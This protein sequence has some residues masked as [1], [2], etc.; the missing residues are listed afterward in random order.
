M[1]ELATD[2][3]AGASRAGCQAS[4]GGHVS[5]GGEDVGV[6]DVEEDPG[7]CPNSDTGHRGQDGG[8]RVDIKNLLD[9]GGQFSALVQR[10]SH[11]ATV[12]TGLRADIGPGVVRRRRPV[13]RQRRAR[14][15]GGPVCPHPGRTHTSKL[16]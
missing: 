1:R 14:R 12:G 10:V 8:K 15:R 3:G 2:A 6:T 16:G 4:V 5:R 7:C 11:P 13:R 9:L